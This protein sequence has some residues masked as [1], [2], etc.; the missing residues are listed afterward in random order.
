[1]S[2]S[3][4]LRPAFVSEESLQVGEAVEAYR[5]VEMLGAEH[6]LVASARSES[7]RAPARRT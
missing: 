4:S 1:M 3:G 2:D 5:R 6:L 7:G